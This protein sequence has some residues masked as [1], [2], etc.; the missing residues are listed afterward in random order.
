[1]SECQFD[2]QPL[3]CAQ[4]GAYIGTFGTCEDFAVC[5]NCSTK[6]LERYVKERHTRADLVYSPDYE[7]TKD[8]QLVRR[9]RYQKYEKP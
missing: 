3:N 6:H 4:C 8:G 2:L 1:M 5:G 7:E 9:T